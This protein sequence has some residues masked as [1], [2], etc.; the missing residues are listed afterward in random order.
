MSFS[1]DVK[2]ELMNILPNG[3]HCQLS[4]LCAINYY[5][6]KRTSEDAKAQKKRISLQKKTGMVEMNVDADVRKS[7]CKRA[8]LRGAFLCIGSVNDP[9][10]SYNLEFVCSNNDEAKKITDLFSSFEIET[11]IN[12]R[13]SNYVV[14]IKEAETIVDVLNILGAHNSL[15]YMENMRVEKEV[16]NSI[17]RKVNCETANIAKAVSA[18]AKQIADIEKI[19]RLMGLEKLEEPLRQMAI[20]RLEH[21]GSSLS[22]LGGYLNPAVGKSGVN[23]RLRKLSEIAKGLD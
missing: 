7:C 11:H 15:M 8:Y 3:R 16:R 6:G 10:R 13:K 4:E 2:E 20:V 5:I 12:I 17:N 22:E 21:R 9:K 23:H 18:S 1:Q 19:D 14:Y